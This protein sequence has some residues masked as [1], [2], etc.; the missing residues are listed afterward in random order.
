MSQLPII[1][2]GSL[3][4]GWQLKTL[5]EYVSK[6]GTGITPNR[7]PDEIFELY[8]VP[9]HETGHPE[10]IAGGEIGSNKQVVED[11]MV[12]LCK[13]NPRINRSWVVSSHTDHQKIASTEWIQFPP[14]DDYDPKYLKYY[15]NQ[16]ALRTYLAANAS[17]VG[18][19]LTRV[20]PATV[21]DYPFPVAPLEDQKR[22]VAEIEKQFSRLDEAVASLKRVKAN[23]NRYKAAAFKAAVEGKL[24][25]EWRKQN[26]DVEPASKLLERILAERRTK[27]EEAELTKMK[28]KGKEPKNDK[29]KE[30]YKASAEISDELP[31]DIPA[32]WSWARLDAVFDVI[33]DGDHQAPPKATTG[34][35]FLVIGNVNRGKLDF[36]NTRFVPKKYFDGLG[37]LRAPRFGDLLYTVVGSYGIPVRVN[38]KEPFCVQRHIAI[39]KP[40]ESISLDYLYYA[41]TSGLVF[42]QA[43]K[44]ATGTAQKTVP[45]TGLRGITI[46]VPPIC[47]QDAIVLAVDSAMSKIEHLEGSAAQSRVALLRQA[48][49]S[50]AFSG[51][52]NGLGDFNG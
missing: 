28:A 52:L 7:T 45:L 6:R 22:I 25:E 1:D 8:S 31:F 48:V 27:W 44:V 34:I 14:S 43:T 20:K 4:K 49:L 32:S 35:P 51:R 40:P 11:G 3:P 41:M 9:S 30:K 46:P 23:L 12:L 42:G 24:T 19:S 37:D 15:L 50:E 2:E 39:L 36:S 10:I 21:K 26:P 33:T 16:E 5:G 13:I 29:W 18:G 38:T 17:G 47:E